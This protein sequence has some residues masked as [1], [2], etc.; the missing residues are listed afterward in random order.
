MR[1]KILALTGATSMAVF[2]PT[3]RAVD[4]Y[5]YSGPIM[6]RDSGLSCF[7]QTT[8]DENNM[9][10]NEFMGLLNRSTSTT[11]TVL[12]PLNRRSSVP[13]AQQAVNGGDFVRIRSLKIFVNNK[14]T[15]KPVSCQIFAYSASMSASHN[16]AMQS[17]TTTG[18]TTITFNDPFGMAFKNESVVNIGYLCTMPGLGSPIQSSGLIGAEAQFDPS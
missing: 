7:G 5:T 12:C 3:A 16:T 14:S 1:L 10:R 17:A 13:Y 15:S 4:P 6:A 8:A 11:M 18:F 2:L 9:V